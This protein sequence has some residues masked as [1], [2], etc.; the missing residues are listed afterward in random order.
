MT[1]AIENIPQEISNSWVEE[2]IQLIQ[3]EIGSYNLL[4]NQLKAQQ[5]AIIDRDILRMTENS[6]NA[7]DYIHMAKEA[8]LKR[9]E[10]IKQVN[11]P[12]R[13]KQELQSIEHVIPIVK[14]QYS[15]RLT[16]LRTTLKAVIKD[17]NHLN[18]V[19]AHLLARSLEH[20]NKNLELIYAAAE[21][22]KNYDAGGN[23]QKF[24]KYSVMMEVV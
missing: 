12:V 9:A 18:K 22:N 8:S 1:I 23:L 21:P 2:L 6:K 11:I 7:Q 13:P 17:I 20:V 5:S 3:D 24:K 14:K 4:L 10:K 15:D 16:E 19:S